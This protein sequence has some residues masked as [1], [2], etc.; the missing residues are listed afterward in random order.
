MCIH[1][2]QNNKTS[3]RR[4]YNGTPVIGL[5]QVNDA[6]YNISQGITSGGIEYIINQVFTESKRNINDPFQVVQ[7]IQP[8]GVYNNR[9]T[10]D[11]QSPFNYVT[12]SSTREIIGVNISNYCFMRDVG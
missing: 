3:R 6:L 2:K 10:H 4:V 1:D 7:V 9:G 5:Q 11:A 12:N 8:F